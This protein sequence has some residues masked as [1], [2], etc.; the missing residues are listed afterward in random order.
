MHA[1][2]L[3]VIFGS[4]NADDRRCGNL[5]LSCSQER[6]P[7]DGRR[8]GRILSPSAHNALIEA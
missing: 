2:L 8:G 7:T 5:L 3:S 1:D 6:W 4:A